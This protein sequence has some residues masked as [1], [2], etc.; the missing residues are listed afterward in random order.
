MYYDL[1][2]PIEVKTA[3]SRFAFLVAKQKGI[4]LTEKRRKR[5]FRQNRYYYLLLGFFSME[6]GY[7]LEE[8]KQLCKRE[9][10]EIFVYTKKDV[11]F[12]RS[13]A[14]LNTKEMSIVIERFRNYAGSNGIYLPE[15]NE[16]D[17]LNHIESNLEKYENKIY[18]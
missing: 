16:V 7:S 10:K 9:S 15:A 14:D 1:S 13:S 12:V 11:K 17:F 2:N 5:T 8:S 3:E 4:N 6:T 18:I